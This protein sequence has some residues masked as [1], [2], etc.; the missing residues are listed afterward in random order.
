M[1]ETVTIDSL[2]EKMI[3]LFPDISNDAIPFLLLVQ[4]CLPRSPA[5][6]DMDRAAV[7]RIHLHNRLLELE[8]EVIRAKELYFNNFTGSIRS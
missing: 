3:K 4:G 6:E 1:I 8:H 2:I 5:P 7:S